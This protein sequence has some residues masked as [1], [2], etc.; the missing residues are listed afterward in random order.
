M[1]QMVEVEKGEAERRSSTIAARNIQLIL[2]EK[3]TS[4]ALM[5]TG[6]ATLALP[7]S[8]LSLLV[9]T[10]RY[11][12]IMGVISFLIPLIGILLMLVCL[13]G[14]FIFRALRN[15]LYQDA[16]ISEIKSHHKELAL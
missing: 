13:G 9:A 5:R 4:L 16:L 11:Y 6:I 10:S 7:L 1:E 3:R 12:H 15:V 14:Y 8:I 2:A